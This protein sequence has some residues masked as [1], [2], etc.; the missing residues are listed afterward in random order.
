MSIPADLNLLQRHVFDPCNFKYTLPKKETE[1]AEYDAYYFKVNGLAV[2]YRKAK[3][4]PTKI[5]QFVT[6]WKRE[7]DGPIQPYG[8][9][10]KVDFLLVSVRKSKNF[11]V[12]VFSRAVLLSQ[13]IISTEKREGKRALRVYPP[14]D[15]PTS[16]QALKTQK[17]QRECFWDV[18]EEKTEW[19]SVRR[20]FI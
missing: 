4:T 2:R 8:I 18:G 13:G 7:D 19:E 10:D 6:F 5:G 1:S 15:I 9:E 3:I 20:L 12:F 11:G 14:W 17:W 16:R